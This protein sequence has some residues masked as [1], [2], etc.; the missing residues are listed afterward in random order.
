M[1]P[2]S[3]PPK[4]KLLHLQEMPTKEQWEEMTEEGL[5]ELVNDIIRGIKEGLKREGIEENSGRFL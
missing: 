1:E 2:E 4:K 3:K 5:D